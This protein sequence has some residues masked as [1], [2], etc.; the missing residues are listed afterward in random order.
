MCNIKIHPF[1]TL[2][3]IV[4]M[5]SN[6]MIWKWNITDGGQLNKKSTGQYK[7]VFQFD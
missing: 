5:Y 3:I 1:T 6:Y 2:K 4:M 7:Y